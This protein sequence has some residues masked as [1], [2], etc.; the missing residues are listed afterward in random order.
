MHRLLYISLGLVCLCA[1]KKDKNRPE[2]PS[3]GTLSASINKAS[4]TNTYPKGYQTVM[5]NQGEYS[6]AIPCINGAYA[7][8]SSL[9][10]ENGYLR[11]TLGFI[12][13]PLDKGRYKI[14]KFIFECNES[15]P[16]Y[17]TFTTTSDDGDVGQDNY[18]VLDIPDNYLEILSYDPKSGEIKGKFQVTFVIERRSLNDPSNL[19]DT[20]RFENGEFFTKIISKN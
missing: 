8:G 5:G 3:W 4:W 20:L 16:P 13:I 14:A 18:A 6:T 19:P 15:D 2:V 1:C 12:K 9:Y 10:N 7:I 17:A 11:Q